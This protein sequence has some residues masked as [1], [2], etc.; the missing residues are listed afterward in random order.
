MPIILKM[1]ADHKANLVPGEPQLN[2]CD[3]SVMNW[4]PQGCKKL[5]RCLTGPQ[6]APHKCDWPHWRVIILI[7]YKNY[8]LCK[9]EMMIVCDINELCGKNIGKTKLSEANRLGII[10]NRWNDYG[11]WNTMKS[12]TCE[13]TTV[14]TECQWYVRVKRPLHSIHVRVCCV[15]INVFKWKQKLTVKIYTD[16]NISNK[17]DYVSSNRNGDGT[18]VEML[19]PSQVGIKMT[20]QT[21]MM[22]IFK[23]KR[24]IF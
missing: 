12:V 3:D 20:L 24:K 7:F 21:E 13:M 4:S 15:A 1:V 22:M 17:Y 6:P 23:Y 19:V 14:F 9:T 8:K 11:I 16:V 5:N 2:W 10:W 18:N